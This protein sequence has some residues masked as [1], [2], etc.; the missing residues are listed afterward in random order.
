MATTTSLQNTVKTAAHDLKR[1]TKVD[2]AH[3]RV[4]VKLNKSGTIKL[5]G[6]LGA[7]PGN[8]SDDKAELQV[9]AGLLLE[10][11]GKKPRKAR[12]GRARAKK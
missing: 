11:G 7:Q 8:D 4:T 9:G 6:Q 12:A 3:K 1:R 5:Y 2:A 10:V